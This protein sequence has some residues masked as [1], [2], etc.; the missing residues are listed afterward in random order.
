MSIEII[1]AYIR[2][3]KETSDIVEIMGIK[4]LII[5]ESALDDAI[6]ALKKATK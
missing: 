2:A 1:E 4:M 3:I 5:P 6:A